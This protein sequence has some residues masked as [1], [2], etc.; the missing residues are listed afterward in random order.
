VTSPNYHCLSF[1]KNLVLFSLLATILLHA[2]RLWAGVT[3]ANE[4]EACDIVARMAAAYAKI[5]SYQTDMEVKEYKKG[6][7]VETKHFLFTFKKPN[8]LRI[9]MKSPKP[10]T[11][12][13]YPDEDGKVILQLGG[14]SKFVKL[15]LAPDNAMLAS[16]AGQRIDQSD[17]GL[18][19]RNIRHSLTDHR[20]GEISLP[21]SENRAII[22]VLADDH[23][24]PNV[25]TGYRFVID[26]TRWLPLEVDES[27]ANGLPRRKLFFK[28]L[29]TPIT[30]K[31][32]FFK[33]TAKVP[34]G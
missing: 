13:L 9:D 31:E 25:Q 26:K 28:E 32:D 15:H 30:V 22:E 18:L 1:K 23:F 6:K 2:T 11:V 14:W 3:P 8:Q 16:G 4:A 21:N 33:S 10:G 29:K 19:I 7:L 24:L 20:H 34:G 27:T 17:F 5:E 12:L